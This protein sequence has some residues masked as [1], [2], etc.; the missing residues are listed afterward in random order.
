MNRPET[1]LCQFI[2]HLTLRSVSFALYRLPWTDEPILVLQKS[3]EVETFES[4]SELNGKRGF[5]LTSFGHSRPGVLIRPDNVARDWEQIGE[6]LAELPELEASE[7]EEGEKS[8]Y[9]DGISNQQRYA[10]AFHRFIEPLQQGRFKKLVLSRCEE[11]ELADGFSLLTAFVNACN[12]YPRMMISLTHTPVTGTWLGCTPEIILSG[13]ENQWHTVSLAGTM[14]MNGETMPEYWSVKNKEEQAF[15]SEYIRKTIKKFGTKLTE[16]GPYTARAGQLVHLKTDFHFCLKNTERLGDILNE[17]HPTPAVC[18]LPKQETYDFILSNEGYDR[19]Y[20]AG[21]IGWID[22]QEHTTLYI[23]LR[24]MHVNGRTA[25]LYA[26]GGI[27]ASSTLET[28][29]DETLHK[30]DTMKR[31]ITL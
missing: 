16:N 17:L 23:N 6:V 8:V 10:E 30:M 1:K 19:G 21:V 9:V 26:G 28:E 15:V 29:W 13:Q 11:H 18:G 3:G 14:P 22:P 7:P 31:I 4:L 12:N 5:V 20:Y 24:C 27:L 25:Q 2:D